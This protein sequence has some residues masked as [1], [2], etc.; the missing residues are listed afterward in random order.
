MMKLNMETELARLTL[1]E[2][3]EAVLQVQTEQ[4]T[5]GEE[6]FFRLVGCF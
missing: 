5:Q 6:G 4:R 2:E 3:E 1:D